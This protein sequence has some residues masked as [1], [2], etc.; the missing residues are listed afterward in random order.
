MKLEDLLESTVRTFPVDVEVTQGLQEDAHSDT[1]SLLPSGSR[2]RILFITTEPAF[3]CQTEPDDR[4]FWI[5]LNYFSKLELLQPDESLDDQT[6]ETAGDVLRAPVRPSWVRVLSGHRGRSTANTIDADEV[7]E[8]LQRGRNERG[9]AALCAIRSVETDQAYRLKQLQVVLSLD[10]V[11]HFTTTAAYEDRYL[12]LQLAEKWTRVP[13][14]V[15]I[16]SHT[17]APLKARILKLQERKVAICVE[18]SKKRPIVIPVSSEI[19]VRVIKEHL[20]SRRSSTCLHKTVNFSNLPRIESFLLEDHS[21]FNDSLTLL[22]DT[23]ST[24]LFPP[25]ASLSLSTDYLCHYE[26]LMHCPQMFGMSSSPL[27]RT[28]SLPQSNFISRNKHIYTTLSRVKFLKE[29]SEREIDA[30]EGDY[31]LPGYQ[32]VEKKHEKRRLSE[33]DV[34]HSLTKSGDHDYNDDSYA[35]PEHELVHRNHERAVS[36]NETS[37]SMTKSDDED[38]YEIPLPDFREENHSR[39]QS[40]IVSSSNM[41]LWTQQE[42]DN[43]TKTGYTRLARRQSQRKEGPYTDIVLQSEEQVKL[44]RLR[45]SNLALQEK[46]KSLQDKLHSLKSLQKHAG[47]QKERIPPKQIASLSC[48]DILILLEN[49]GLGMYKQNVIDEALEGYLLCDCSKDFLIDLGMKS[50]HACKFLALVKGRLPPSTTWT[51]LVGKRNP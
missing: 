9:E 42:R 24:V 50:V 31:E 30:D 10:T 16:R 44:D 8:N 35:V 6:F 7:L 29:K 48:T 12:P 14:R 39:S 15:R 19:H 51:E 37:S 41:D 45:I 3:R 43:N 25:S 36:L 13:Q 27:Q 11:G 4:P 20:T 17:H 40:V 34:G 38:D 23:Q 26:T 22:S 18:L 47:S 49:L 33:A 46:I 32:Q 28:P 21:H 2:I 1:P 5:S